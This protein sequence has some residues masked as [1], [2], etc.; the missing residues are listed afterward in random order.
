MFRKRL[1]ELLDMMGVTDISDE[2]LDSLQ[3]QLFQFMEFD[4]SALAGGITFKTGSILT[5]VAVHN[6]QEIRDQLYRSYQRGEQPEKMN[7][8]LVMTSLCLYLLE[9]SKCQV[10][11]EF[12]TFQEDSS[13]WWECE[14]VQASCQ[15]DDE[16][17]K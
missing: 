3:R 2:M 5:T 6:Y 8:R 7:L 15:S 13:R 9:D 12:C 4:D 17:W 16:E 11:N 1:R 14:I 10:T